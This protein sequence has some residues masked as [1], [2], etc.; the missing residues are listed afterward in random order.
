MLILLVAC[1]DEKPVDKKTPQ[2][3][4]TLTVM[5]TAATVTV[6]K[7][8]SS[9]QPVK[10]KL[11]VVPADTVISYD[12]MD[13]SLEGSEAKVHYIKGSIRDVEWEIFGETGQATIYYNFLPN[14]TVKVRE[15][16]SSYDSGMQYVRSDKDVHLKKIIEY[17]LDT[18]GV[19]L[20]KTKDIMSVFGEFKKVVPLDLH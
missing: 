12:I 11:A 1:K 4:T 20:S 9:P 2:V 17:Q 7:D 19:L 6:Q 16:R 15:K 8:T 3:D 5:D 14:G 18:N 13:V 10:F